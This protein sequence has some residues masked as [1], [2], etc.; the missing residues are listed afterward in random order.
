MYQSGQTALQSMGW[1]Q[2]HQSDRPTFQA[3]VSRGFSGRVYS[4]FAMQ[5]G[6]LFLEQVDTPEHQLET[7]RRGA[8]AGALVGGVMGAIVGEMLASSVSGPI[9]KESGL[10][11]LSDEELFALARNRKRSFVAERDDIESVSIDAPKGLSS[12]FK[13]RL[14]G[15]VTIRDRRL[16]KVTL[17]LS[18]RTAMTVAIDAFPRHYGNRALVNVRWDQRKNCYVSDGR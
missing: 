10:E 13:S 1:L 3:K 8:A 7:A 14:L 9:R 6:L 12:L 4:I 15:L 17:E 2:A 16:G 5:H 11:T 18:D